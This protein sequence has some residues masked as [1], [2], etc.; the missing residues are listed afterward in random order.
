MKSREGVSYM[1][2]AVGFECGPREINLNRELRWKPRK[3]GAFGSS[4]PLEEGQ[5]LL[6]SGKSPDRILR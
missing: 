3:P 1:L 6:V 2:R 4:P 5:K